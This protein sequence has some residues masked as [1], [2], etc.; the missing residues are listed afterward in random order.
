MSLEL[1]IPILALALGIATWS[2]K[3]I[4]S[5]RL[6]VTLIPGTPNF[7][8]AEVVVSLRIQNEGSDT[9][10]LSFAEAQFDLIPGKGRTFRAESKWFKHSR[11]VVPMEM[12]HNSVRIPFVHIGEAWRKLRNVIPRGKMRVGL[13]KRNKVRRTPWIEF[14]SG[15]FEAKETVSLELNEAKA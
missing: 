2:W 15:S 10:E 13:K 6:K 9:Y 7:G 14:N 5:R 8:P 4:E 1:L 3:V 12:H 11:V